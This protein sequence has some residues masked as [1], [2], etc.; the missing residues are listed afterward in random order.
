MAAIRAEIL[1]V[2]PAGLGHHAYP[3]NVATVVLGRA[4]PRAERGVVVHATAAR[5]LCCLLFF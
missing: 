4:L 2:M 1:L 5:D 3:V